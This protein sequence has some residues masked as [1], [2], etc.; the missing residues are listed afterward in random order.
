MQAAADICLIVEGGYP[1]VV[2]GVASWM[3]AF[4][5]ASAGLKFHVITITISSQSR[6]AKFA[7][8]DNVV[9][10]TDVVLDACPPGRHPSVRD[11]Q[12]IREGVQLLQSALG[13]DPERGFPSLVDL[14]SRTGFAQ[15]ALLDSKPA[16]VAMEHAYSELVHDAP[17]ID[18]FWSWRFLAQSLLSVISTPLPRAHVFHAVSAGYA[19][20]LGA[21]AK[22]VTHRPYVVTEH[23]IYTNERRI[24]LSVADWIFDS[25]VSGFSVGRKPAQL[26]DLWL[27]AFSNFSRIS[28]AFAD[29]I[30]TQYRAN[31]DYQRA[32]GAPEHKLCIIPN[33]ID[34]DAYA[35]IRRSTAPRPPTV[36]MIGRIVP[37]KDTRTFIMAMALL[38]GLVPDVVAFLIGPEDEDPA[39]AV[40]CHELVAQLGLEQTVRFL[41]RVPDVNEYLAQSDVVTLTSISEAQP[42]AMLEAAATGLPA[43]TTDVGSCREVLEGFDGDP[44]IGRGGIVVDACNPKSIAEALATILTNDRMRAEMGRIMQRRIVEVYHKE[45]VRRMYEDL[46]SSVES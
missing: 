26:R 46:Y 38:K 4:M 22:H 10:I 27:T 5:R 28:Y 34:A 9:G 32:D 23:G 42:L 44:V 20:V 2:G 11:E 15:G 6:V 41:G 37:I 14:V 1:Y 31:Q 7:I 19:G 29:V 3:D 25:G 21:Y 39:Y 35:R 36:L 8:P 17:F 45:R 30:T 33:G 24:E 16:W 12:S 13:S 43:V 18:F 40:G